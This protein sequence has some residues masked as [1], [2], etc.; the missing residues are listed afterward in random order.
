M[1]IM[2]FKHVLGFVIFSENIDFKLE[3]REKE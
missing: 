1:N 3:N 2:N